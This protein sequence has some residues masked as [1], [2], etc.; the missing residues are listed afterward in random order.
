MVL[1]GSS[2]LHGSCRCSCSGLS[3]PTLTMWI[4]CSLCSANQ[5]PQGH[6]LYL[7]LCIHRTLRWILHDTFTGQLKKLLLQGFSNAVVFSGCCCVHYSASMFYTS[8][9]SRDLPTF[10]AVPSFSAQVRLHARTHALLAQQ[11]S[12]C[13]AEAQCL[14]LPHLQNDFGV[15]NK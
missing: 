12:W 7:T 5:G 15:E 4:S 3:D 14:Q 6:L 10:A 8:P 9:T 2:E 11:R 1:C 13:T